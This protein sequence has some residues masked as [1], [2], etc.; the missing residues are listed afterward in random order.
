[1]KVFAIEDIQVVG[2][3]VGRDSDETALAVLKDR[4]DAV[5]V[6]AV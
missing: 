1:V 3:L 5:A 2:A 6:Q 4:L